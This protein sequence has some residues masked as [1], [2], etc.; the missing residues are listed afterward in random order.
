MY[1]V[2]IPLCKAIGNFPKFRMDGGLQFKGMLHWKPLIINCM[3]D[4][5]VL[6]SHIMNQ[7]YEPCNQ[8]R[9]P[10]VDCLVG[11][12]SLV[13]LQLKPPPPLFG[14]LALNKV[15]SANFILINSCIHTEWVCI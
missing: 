14:N 7:F 13:V 4:C 15:L 9:G 1:I 10:L 3:K 6:L 8:P 11:E 12:L 2:L 5:I